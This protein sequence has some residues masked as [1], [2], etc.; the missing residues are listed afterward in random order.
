MTWPVAAPLASPRLRLE[1]LAVHHAE[2]MVGVLADPSL[3]SFTGGEPPTLGRL[4]IRYA[5]QSTGQSPTGETGWLNWIIRDRGSDTA[6]GYV[7][8]TLTR[9][10]GA[11]IAD[12]GWLVKPDAQGAGIA[13][14]AVREMVTW[15]RTQHVTRVRASI[16]PDHVTSAGV[17][18]RVGLTPTDVVVDGERVWEAT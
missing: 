18:E 2:E 5:G 6:L 10:H 9:D 8:A 16:R 7:Q 4:R 13:T 15:L 11:L 3:Y 1:P 17:A 14:E 12:A